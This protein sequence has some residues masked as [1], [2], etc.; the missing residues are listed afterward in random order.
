MIIVSKAALC[1]FL[2]GT[3]DLTKRLEYK[4]GGAFGRWGGQ[5]HFTPAVTNPQLLMYTE[6]GELFFDSSP[7]VGYSSAGRPLCYDFSQ[8][9]YRVYFVEG[10]STEPE[11]R[12]FHDL[13]LG[14]KVEADLPIGVSCAFD[15]MCV[16]DLYS[17]QIA[18]D[19]QDSFSIIWNVD[20]PT[21]HGYTTQRYK[22]VSP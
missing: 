21:K 12:H 5:A 18:I 15:H 13:A 22:R 1:S 20:G 11:L 3:W 9:P 2:A 7:K 10:G 14:S 19:S 16:K 8:W 17:G 6:E 4:R